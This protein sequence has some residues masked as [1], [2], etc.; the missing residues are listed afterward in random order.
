MED[1]AIVALYWA[2]DEQALAETA[3]KFGAYCR[4][5]ADN[6]LHS[7]HDVE[8]CENDTWL[9]AWNSM[10]DN[11]PARLAPYLGRITRNL[12]LDR[13]DKATA[14][15][16]GSGQQPA[17]PDDSIHRKAAPPGS[18]PLLCRDR[19]GE[20]QRMGQQR[21]VR[22]GAHATGGSPHCSALHK[23]GL[24]KRRQNVTADALHHGQLP[25]RRGSKKGS[26]LCFHILA[27]CQA[28]YGFYGLA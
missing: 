21:A 25:R 1:A 15:K 2:R 19:P 11:R 14:Q 10:P 6:I 20:A 26:K 7:A 9:A 23:I 3:T 5:I 12:A 4:K 22:P 27:A 17:L 16:R 18:G 13:L 8:E 28:L 24:V